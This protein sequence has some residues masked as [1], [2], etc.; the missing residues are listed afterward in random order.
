VGQSFH[1]NNLA[2]AGVRVVCAGRATSQSV[3]LAPDIADVCD[4]KVIVGQLIS[5]LSSLTERAAGNSVRSEYLYIPGYVFQAMWVRI[6]AST[7]ISRST[8]SAEL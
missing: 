5:R 8:S 4:V 1:R 6:V 3:R 2:V 7:R